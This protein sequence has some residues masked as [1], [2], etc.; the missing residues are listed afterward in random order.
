MADTKLNVS[1]RWQYHPEVKIKDLVVPEM[2]MCVAKAKSQAYMQ[3]VPVSAYEDEK[4]RAAIERICV[5]K[6]LW[7]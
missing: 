3:P 7:A 4:L 1:I 5:E 6:V 2:W